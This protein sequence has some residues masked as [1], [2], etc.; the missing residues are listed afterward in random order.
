MDGLKQLERHCQ[1]VSSEYPGIAVTGVAVGNC[2]KEEEKGNKVD[3]K[4]EAKSRG[5]W[6]GFPSG[7]DIIFES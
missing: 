5:F 3:L 6:L 1:R 2:L 7:N 4:N